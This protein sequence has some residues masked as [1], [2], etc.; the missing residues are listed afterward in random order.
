M[1][2]HNLPVLQCGGLAHQFQTSLGSKHG[3]NRSGWFQN[4]TGGKRYGRFEI[5][6]K[7]LKPSELVIGP[8]HTFHE[9]M[10]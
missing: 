1:L 2:L 10:A 7:V 6:P 5:G 8:Q 9:F 3:N 4:G